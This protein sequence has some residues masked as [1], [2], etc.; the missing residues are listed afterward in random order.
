MN[1]ILSKPLFMPVFSFGDKEL[2]KNN[3]EDITHYYSW[4]FAERC[5]LFFRKHD[6]G[7][8]RH[9]LSFSKSKM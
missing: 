1:Y 8:C 2:L 9:K 3:A 6:S 5:T 7:S 4:F